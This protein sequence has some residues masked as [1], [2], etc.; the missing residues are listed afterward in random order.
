[1]PKSLFQIAPS[2]VPIFVPR[3]FAKRPELA[4]MVSET[5]A[6]W[7]Y[8]ENSLGKSLAAMERGKSAVE[9]KKYAKAHV[10]SNKKVILEK[11]ARA[12][13]TGLYLSTFLGTVDVISRFAKRRNAFAH[14]IW[15]TVEA[16]PDAM[17]LV[18]PKHLFA[19]WGKANDWV[20]D[21]ARDPGAVGAASHFNSANVEVWT[22]T[23]LEEEISKMNRAYDLATKLEALASPG[24]FTPSDARQAHAH[25][26]LLQDCD[27][28]L[29]SVT[30]A[31]PAP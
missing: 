7:A 30:Y 15:G 27:V 11:A 12:Q 19:H 21:F 23:D 25:M 13:L 4:V 3:D 18:D 16:L 22:R 20:D 2:E 10:F 9:M 24:V 17:L 26:L 28:V 5:I 29:A 8:A 14:G 1:M 6:T 31:S